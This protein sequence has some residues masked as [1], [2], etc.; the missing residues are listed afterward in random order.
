MQQNPTTDEQALPVAPVAAALKLD[1]DTLKKITPAMVRVV[2]ARAFDMS[3]AQIADREG[4]SVPGLNKR[5]DRVH[6][7][8]GVQSTTAAYRVLLLVGLLVVK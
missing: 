7:L 1:A 2:E 5:L 3:M 4:V 6:K 8:L